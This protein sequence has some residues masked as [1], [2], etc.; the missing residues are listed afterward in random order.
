[1]RGLK[2]KVAIV[3]GGA[4]GIG[5]ATCERFVREGV[6]VVIADIDEPAA[7]AVRSSLIA[8]GG[9]AVAVTTDVSA[10]ASVA[11]LVARAATEFG[12]ID[13]LINCAATFIMRGIE[14]TVEE[15][16]RVLAINVV[17]CALSAKH[18]VP[19][20]RRAEGGTIVNVCSI[21]ALV[22]Q[23]SFLTYSATKGALLTMT[24]CM[25][26]DLAADRIRV[27][28]VSPGTVWTAS[29][30]AFILRTRGFGR[31]EADQHPDIGG[32]HV[33]SR[34]ADPGEIAS[35][36]TFLASDE[37]SFITGTN[38]LVDGGYTVR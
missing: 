32:L 31:R 20:M 28:A 3:T 6:G 19:H 38:L 25:A 26:L 35:A 9:Q 2:G 33:L 14:A 22:A 16:S 13:I 12:R 4:A 29:N 18:V 5:R 15:W 27:N 17:G 7:A 23:P 10:E 24:R 1:M 30:E 37:A 11:A 34:T 8:L 36:I 21:S